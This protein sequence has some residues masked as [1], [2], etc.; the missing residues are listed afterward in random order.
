MNGL[1]WS[2]IA[3]LIATT[4]VAADAEQNGVNGTCSGVAAVMLSATRNQIPIAS[5]PDGSCMVPGAVVPIEIVAQVVDGGSN[6]VADCPVAFWIDFTNI[7]NCGRAFGEFCDGS[8]A[9]TDAAGRARVR[10][11]VRQEDLDFCNCLP[12]ACDPSLCTAPRSCARQCNVTDDLYCQVAISAA[13]GT[14][15]STNPVVI[16][17][18]R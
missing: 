2:S 17:Y 1:A 11:T 12:S 6:G 4:V 10:L 18:G 9:V 14:I 8:V 16:E 5:A 13:A 15:E 3:L 7:A